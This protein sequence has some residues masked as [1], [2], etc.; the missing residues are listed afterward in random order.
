VV[1]LDMV[2]RLRHDRV[3]VFGA[4]EPQRRALL[5]R[6]NIE[7]PL[8]LTLELTLEFTLEIQEQWPLG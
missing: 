3:T 7:P 5:H 1:N 2:G 6:A 4:N 8:A